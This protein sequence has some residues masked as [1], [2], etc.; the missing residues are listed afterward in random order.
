MINKIMDLLR[1]WTSIDRIGNWKC[2]VYC[3]LTQCEGFSV[4]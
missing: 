2:N 3:R 4:N 1:L